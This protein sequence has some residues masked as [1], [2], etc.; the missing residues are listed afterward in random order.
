MVDVRSISRHQRTPPPP[1]TPPN[2]PLPILVG[3][4]QKNASNR[5]PLVNVP[6]PPNTSTWSDQLTFYF[7]RSPFL[8]WTHHSRHRSTLISNYSVKKLH[9]GVFRGLRLII[10]NL[11]LLEIGSCLCQVNH[12]QWLL[13]KQFANLRSDLCLLFRIRLVLF[14]SHVFAESIFFCICIVLQHIWMNRVY[15]FLFWWMSRMEICMCLLFGVEF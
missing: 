9:S 6:I 7:I 2:Y 15:G 5:Y 4:L 8:W 11:I 1:G 10:L 12:P 14:L 3:E 13:W